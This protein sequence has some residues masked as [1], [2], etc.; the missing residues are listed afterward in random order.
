MSKQLMI[1]NKIHEDE[2]RSHEKEI[3]RHLDSIKRHRLH[4]DELTNFH[5]TKK[6]E[7]SDTE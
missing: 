1:L 5:F 6:N 4:Q 2:I 7:C 3:Q